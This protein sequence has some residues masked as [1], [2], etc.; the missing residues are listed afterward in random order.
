VGAIE[1]PHA[2][3]FVERAMDLVSKTLFTQLTIDMET[4]FWV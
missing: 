2:Q 1:N 4:L 3:T